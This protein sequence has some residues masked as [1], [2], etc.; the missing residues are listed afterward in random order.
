MTFYV[1]FINGIK[2]VRESDGFDWAFGF[3]QYVAGAL[4]ESPIYIYFLDEDGKQVFI[5]PSHY[6][7]NS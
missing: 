4:P 1:E 2:Q 6:D 7:W 3:A 5:S